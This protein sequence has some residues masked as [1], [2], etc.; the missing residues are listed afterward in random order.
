MNIKKICV[1]ALGIALY[2]AISMTAKI[3]IISHISLDLGYIVLA[4]YCYYYGAFVGAV[5]GAAGCC[6]ISVLTTGMFPAGWMLGNVA[7]GIICGRYY[8]KGK[9]FKN[10]LLSAGSVVLGILLIKTL[11]E[12]SLYSIP[13]EVKFVKNGVAAMADATVMS[14]GALIAQK[15]EKIV[16]HYIGK[17]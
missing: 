3:P 2:F 8:E 5:V 9:S 1:S 17:K 6:A 16:N 13:Y 7:I 15:T 10:V 4:F 12:C 14:I 11:V